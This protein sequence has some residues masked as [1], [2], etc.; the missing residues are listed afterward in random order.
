MVDYGNCP[1]LVRP[2]AT[3]QGE[4]VTAACPAFRPHGYQAETSLEASPFDRHIMKTRS[5][6]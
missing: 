5:F 1:T 4:T 3:S 2:L 6:G